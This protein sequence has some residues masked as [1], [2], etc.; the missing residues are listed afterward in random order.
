MADSFSNNQTFVSIRLIL[1]FYL[2]TYDLTIYGKTDKETVHLEAIHMRLK[3]IG[4]VTA[5]SFPILYRP[6]TEYKCTLI[7]P[8]RRSLRRGEQVMIRMCLPNATTVRVDNGSE[9]RLTYGYENEVLTTDL[10]V[11]GDVTVFGIFDQ[12]EQ[13]Q[14]ICKFNMV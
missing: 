14:P 7:E 2:G 1:N 6:F 13:L 8:F 5:P 9:T 3:V 4:L 11:E 12:T 10:I